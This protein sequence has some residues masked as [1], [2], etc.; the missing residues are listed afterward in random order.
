MSNTPK[1]LFIRPKEE[2][3]SDLYS[4]AE[5]IFRL[6]NS[7]RDPNEINTFLCT[8]YEQ[9]N[10]DYDMLTERAIPLKYHVFFKSGEEGLGLPEDTYE[11]SKIEKDLVRFTEHYN[12]LIIRP[13]YYLKEARSKAIIKGGIAKELRTKKILTPIYLGILK[14]IDNFV[15]PRIEK[16]NDKLRLLEEKITRYSQLRVS[17]KR[18]RPKRY[19]L[20]V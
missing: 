4:L 17:E 9:S 3:N 6:Y 1:V 15:K 7:T 2:D 19:G 18:R 10:T 20:I 13:N 16:D 14:T 12:N 5:I 8:S 11:L